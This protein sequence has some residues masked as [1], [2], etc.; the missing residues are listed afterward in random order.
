[1]QTQYSSS[2]RRHC[3]SKSALNSHPGSDM[4]SR[5][6]RQ[7]A[8]LQAFL[9]P[10]VTPNACTLLKSTS[11][12]FL[13]KAFVCNN[14][15]R[16]LDPHNDP[17]E[18]LVQVQAPKYWLEQQQMMQGTSS[19]KEMRLGGWEK[20]QIWHA[21]NL[22]VVWPLLKKSMRMKHQPQAPLPLKLLPWRWV[23]MLLTGFRGTNIMR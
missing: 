6:D 13:S 21:M 3:K 14:N 8:L 10:K 17:G 12:V 5:H 4:G 7:P 1:M 18:I 15:R 22:L 2:R 20:M 11:W 23:C 19:S 9:N 16:P